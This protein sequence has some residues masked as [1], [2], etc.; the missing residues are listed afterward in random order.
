MNYKAILLLLISA[1]L[2]GIDHVVQKVVLNSGISSLTFAFIRI[3]TA[4]LFLTPY[5]FYIHNKKRFKFTKQNIRDLAILGVLA[6]G[7]AMLF[8][9]SGLSYTTAT[10]AGFMQVMVALFAIIFSYFILKERL[11]KMFFVILSIMLL[12]IML[13]TTQGGIVLPNKGDMILLLDVCLVG[14][15]VVYAKR[16]M[17]W[18]SSRIIAYG[19]AVFGAIFLALL[20]PFIGFDDFSIILP[21]LGLIIFSGINFALRIVFTYKAIDIENAS[22][23]TTFLLL[24]PVVT[25]II[26]NLWLGETLVMMQYA[27][28]LLVFFGAVMLAML[29]PSKHNF[30]HHN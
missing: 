15:S 21:V 28:V 29:K 22:N 5:F 13:I 10:N 7:L 18:M 25:L 9:L 27:G 8:K 19:G 12:G 4:A 26:A 11:P 14:F 3:L 16:V 23:V 2:L 6:S 30:V 17:N 20:I 1:I 24:A